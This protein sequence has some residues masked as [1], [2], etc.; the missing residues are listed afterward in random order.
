MIKSYPINFQSKTAKSSKS[1]LKISFHSIL[2][3]ISFS[4]GRELLAIRKID[5]GLP[6]DRG[7]GD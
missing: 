2:I 4:R 5:D 7:R 6:L 3:Y 1:R